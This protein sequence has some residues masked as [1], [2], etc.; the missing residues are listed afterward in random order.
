MTEEPCRLLLVDDEEEFVAATMLLL[1]SEGFRVSSAASGDQALAMVR[2][3][4]RP[5]L[6]LLDSRMPGLTGGETLAR[7]REEGLRSPAILVSA[8]RDLDESASADGFDAALAK[9]FE[10]SELL[11]TVRGVLG[12]RDGHG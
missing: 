12:S 7:M 5:D 9:P 8:R 2:R 11:L 1:E 3:G 4:L 6:L 10:F